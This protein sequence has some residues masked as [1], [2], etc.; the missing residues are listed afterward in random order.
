VAKGGKIWKQRESTVLN[1][2]YPQKMNIKFFI[3]RKK[4][5]ETGPRVKILTCLEKEQKSKRNRK[6]FKLFLLVH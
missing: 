3:K 1:I 4:K 5:S 2:S 6:I